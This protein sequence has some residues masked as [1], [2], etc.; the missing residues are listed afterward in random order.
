MCTKI[1]DFKV[2]YKIIYLN[3]VWFWKLEYWRSNLKGVLYKKIERNYKK[4]I[5]KYLESGLKTGDHHVV[6]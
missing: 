2:F 3:I 1:N 4:I 5:E 6:F